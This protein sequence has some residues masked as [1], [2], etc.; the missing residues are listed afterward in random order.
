[1]HTMLTLDAAH[2]PAVSGSNTP[3]HSSH[4]D[5]DGSRVDS[6]QSFS[7]VATWA[8][9]ALSAITPSPSHNDLDEFWLDDFWFPLPDA[10]YAP[11]PT[12]LDVNIP[13]AFDVNSLTSFFPNNL[14][15]FGV[16]KLWSPLPDT[17]HIP[18]PSLTTSN[19]NTPPLSLPP[20][21]QNGLDKFC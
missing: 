3:H 9:A 12:A 5:F 8:S 2:N 21:L 15:N 14:D 19:T 1:M 16:D 20:S 10:R 17:G 18:Y 13:A 6:L 7:S 4:G 11:L